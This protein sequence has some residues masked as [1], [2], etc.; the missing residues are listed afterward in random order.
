MRMIA[1]KK[2]IGHMLTV[3][4]GEGHSATHWA[5]MIY[6]FIGPIMVGTQFM[7]MGVR[8]QALRNLMTHHEHVFSSTVS[9]DD[10][11]QLQKQIDHRL[12]FNGLSDEE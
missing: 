5:A 2:V 3:K 11:P 4:V 6:S 7:S 8:I 12:M 9:S 10:R 1:G